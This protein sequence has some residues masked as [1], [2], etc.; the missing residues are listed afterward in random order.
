MTNL[1]KRVLVIGMTENPG[2]IEALLLNVLNHSDPARIRFDF[3]ANVPKVA[4][5]ERLLGHSCKVYHVTM[6]RENRKKNQEELEALFKEHSSEYDAVWE[7]ATSLANIDYLILAKKYGIP[8]RIMHGHNSTN[9][10]GLIRGCFHNLNRR[11]IRKIA[12]HFWSVSDEAS[13]WLFGSDYYS[14]PNYRVINNTIDVDK[15]AFNDEARLQIRSKY[16]IPEQAVLVGNVGRL[17]EQ[18]N[19][20]LFISIIAELN[21]GNRPV[22]GLILGEGSLRNE[23]VSQACDLG[24]LDKLILP[25]VVSDSYRYYSAFDLFLFP[26]LSEGLGIAL[27][28]AQANGVPC[29]VSNG[30][31]TKALLNLNTARCELDAPLNKWVRETERLLSIGRTEELAIVGSPFDARNSQAIFDGILID[32]AN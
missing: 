1:P 32:G 29:L 6:R 19:Q 27:L 20:K 22:Y 24:I 9:S 5:E 15:F 28:E 3:I 16:N 17:H 14:L 2:G 11:R 25:G 18:K 23:I 10:E 30:I 21:K 7:N 31:P 4:F 8:V 26:S 13:P 12:T